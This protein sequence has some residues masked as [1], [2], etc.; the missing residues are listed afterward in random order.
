[1]S[2]PVDSKQLLI[3]RLKDK[4]VI[5]KIQHTKPDG[6]VYYDIKTYLPYEV[7]IEEIKKL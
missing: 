7:V 1:M 4:K 5:H 6:T 2:N 3:E